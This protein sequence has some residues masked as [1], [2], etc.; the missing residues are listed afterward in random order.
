MRGIIYFL[1]IQWIKL[2]WFFLGDYYNRLAAQ[3]EFLY[4]QSDLFKLRWQQLGL[5]Y[6]ESSFTENGMGMHFFE[7]AKHASLEIRWQLL[8]DSLTGQPIRVYYLKDE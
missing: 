7:K 4:R 8:K 1:K 2:R 6:A 3:A 5:E